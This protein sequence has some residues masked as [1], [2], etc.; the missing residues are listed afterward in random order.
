[1]DPL[2]GTTVI[3]HLKPAMFSLLFLMA[4]TAIEGRIFI[5]GFAITMGCVRVIN[6]IRL[7]FTLLFVV[8]AKLSVVEQGKE[9]VHP[10][11]VT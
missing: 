7:I 6:K 5:V 2:L 9:T 8:T 10:T 1:M 11:I 4:L 3:D